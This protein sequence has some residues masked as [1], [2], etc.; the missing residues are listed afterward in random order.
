MAD[1]V[2]LAGV[3][4]DVDFADKPKNLD[5]MEDAM[6][7]TAKED[8]R[9]VVFPE[10]AVTG[11]CFESLDEAMTVAEPVEGPSLAR[12]ARLCQELRQHV[13]VG[14]LEREG[15]R[16]YNSAALIGPGEVLGVY[17]KIH[18]PHLGVDRFVTPGRRAT[19]VFQAG[20][21]RIGMNICYD[22]TFPEA[23]RCLALD[24]ADLIA[25]PTNWPPHAEEVAEHVINT[26]AL[27]N[28]VYYIAV[29][30]VGTERGFRFIG[31]SK[32]ASPVGRTL[33]R[34]EKDEETILYA[35]IDPSLPRDKHLVR[36]PGK[37]EIHRWNDR[38]PEL[39][40]PITREK[41]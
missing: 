36:V 6:R 16:L 7:R 25:L 8:A 17:R 14:T 1:L 27:E 40:S 19:D 31:M 29:N 37:H 11:Y 2:R 22:T 35:D 39:Y 23:A 33:A 21:V 32:I 4:M 9:I 5:R 3:Q 30:R 13:V 15:D 41:P 38:R 12:L 18:L 10:C 34:A 26:R 28:H 24:G 20:T